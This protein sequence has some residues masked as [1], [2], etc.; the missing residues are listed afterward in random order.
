[1]TDTERWL[2]QLQRDANLTDRY[3]F[4]AKKALELI[5]KQSKEIA[6]RNDRWETLKKWVQTPESL[7]RGVSSSAENGILKKMQELES[8]SF[9]NISLCKSCGCMTHSLFSMFCG[10]CGKIKPDGSEGDKE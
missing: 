7:F 4:I 8:R 6:A 3:G 10:K 2:E 9:D 1:M 5:D